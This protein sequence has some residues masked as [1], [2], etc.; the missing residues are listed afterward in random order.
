MEKYVSPSIHTRLGE[1]ALAALLC[2]VTAGGAWAQLIPTGSITGVVK[3]PKGA[4]VPGVAIT[5]TN[6]ATGIVK[7]TKTN[8]TGVFLVPDMLPGTYRVEAQFQG[9]KKISQVGTVQTGESTTFDLTLQLGST[10][11]TVEVSG[12][13]PL[14]QATTSS[15]TTTI[16]GRNIE[17]LPLQGRNPLLLT[18]LSPGVVQTFNPSPSGVDT[19]AMN[20]TS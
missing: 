5:V 7:A 10:K 1:Y 14:L 8:S 11:Q 12:R 18:R 6:T 3:D 19:N 16:S 20:Q 2:L 4:V 17:N 15:L 13:A 9:F